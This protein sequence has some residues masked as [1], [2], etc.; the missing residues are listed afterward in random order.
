VHKRAA[1]L[2]AAVLVASATVTG[3]AMRHASQATMDLDP[4]SRTGLIVLI[5]IIGAVPLASVAWLLHTRGAPAGPQTADAGSAE[6]DIAPDADGPQQELDR[7]RVAVERA[8]AARSEFLKSMSHEMRTPLNGVLGLMELLLS[9]RLDPQQ[10]HYVAVARASATHLATLITDI[11]DLSRMEDGALVLERT[12]FDLPDLVESSL[13]AVSAEASRKRLRLSC[14]VT[15]DVPTWVVGDPGRLRQVLVNLLA[16]AVKFTERGEVHVHAGAEVDVHARTALL[17]IDVHDTG[18]GMTPEVVDRL[19]LP[20]T[21]GDA[22]ST[23]R[24]G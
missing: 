1:W 15:E 17:R 10:A 23:R 18:I 4:A 21:P 22:S 9:T 12:L 13:D 5:G 24:P 2:G 19:F 20:F 16:N 7:A 14:T 11:L 8:S 6:H 3:L